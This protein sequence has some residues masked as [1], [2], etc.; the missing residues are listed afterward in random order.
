MAETARGRGAFWGSAILLLEP[1][2]GRRAVLPGLGACHLHA[3]SQGRHAFIQCPAESQCNGPGKEGW[4]SLVR[5]TLPALG[6]GEAGI[7]YL[8]GPAWSPG[9]DN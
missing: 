4:P 5:P 1:G 7:L 9:W 6:P 3:V 2:G 8:E